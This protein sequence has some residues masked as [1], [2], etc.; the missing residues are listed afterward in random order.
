MSNNDQKLAEWL[1]D[2]ARKYG[3][4]FVMRSYSNRMVYIYF[5]DETMESWEYEITNQLVNEK[6]NEWAL[7]SVPTETTVP[8]ISYEVAEKLSY[9]AS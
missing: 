8:Q 1:L 9:Y 5:F 3:D 2:P 4:M 7:T 6:A